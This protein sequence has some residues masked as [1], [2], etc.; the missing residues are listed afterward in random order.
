M[1]T[2]KSLTAFWRLKRAVSELVIIWTIL[3]YT[4][5]YAICQYVEENGALSET[6]GHST[7][8]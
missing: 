1:N 6:D 2:A 5:L 8:V 7:Y 3:Y 4:I